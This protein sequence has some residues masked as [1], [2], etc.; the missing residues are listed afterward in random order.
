MYCKTI[1]NEVIKDHIG[2]RPESEDII[3][4]VY[5]YLSQENKVNR[6]I[7]AALRKTNVHHAGTLA[8]ATGYK[9]KTI[10]THLKWLSG[11]GYITIGEN[12]IDIGRIFDCSNLGQPFSV[13]AV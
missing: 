9:L 4:L 13:A 7:I 10:K 2:H 1:T 3:M 11:N 12:Q 5:H 8:Q 6:A